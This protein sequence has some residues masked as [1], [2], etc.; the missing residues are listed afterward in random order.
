MQTNSLI[1]L[2]K[3]EAPDWTRAEILDLVADV[4]LIM[5]SKPLQRNRMI[6]TDTG[7]DPVLTT[8]SGTYSYYINTSNGFD[9]DALFIESVYST[10][11]PETSYNYD[12]SIEIDGTD[13]YTFPGNRDNAAQ[14]IFKDNPSG[15][16][17]IRCYRKPDTVSTQY[18]NLMIPEWW[19]FKGVRVGVL[20][21][22]ELVEHGTSKNWDQFE[23]KVLPQFHSEMNMSAGTLGWKVGSRGY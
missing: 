11:S 1:A 14:V 12:E 7:L 22:I 8:T 21:M 18:T 13:V 16:Y 23:Q 17:Y 3:R 20:G 6:D 10:A 19:H 2:I 9:Y 5:L 15:D 4:Q